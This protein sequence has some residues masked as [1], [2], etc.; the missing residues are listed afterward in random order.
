MS[1][2]NIDNISNEEL[3]FKPKKRFLFFSPFLILLLGFVII[4][5]LKNHFQ[6]TVLSTLVAIIYFGLLFYLFK[7]NQKDKQLIE[8]I[9]YQNLDIKRYLSYLDYVL[10]RQ[11]NKEKNV[12]LNNRIIVDF[13]KGNFEAACLAFGNESI[14]SK[15]KNSPENS[16]LVQ[17]YYHIL[18]AIHSFKDD[19]YIN[20]LFLEFENISLK[21]NKNK[22]LKEVLLQNCSEIRQLIILNKNLSEISKM[23]SSKKLI[24]LM[25]DYYEGRNQLIKE[26][27]F[28]AKENFQKIANEN[29]ELFYVREAKK[30]LEEL[31]NE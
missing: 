8:D 23:K 26:N 15:N 22:K 28:A 3:Y 6:L 29:P 5:I 24:Q 2:P 13:Y 10:Q 17:K 1:L 7:E 19:N 14:S 12:Y 16:L 31:D 4:S 11:K 18:S 27:K 9:L 30:Y 21:N 20:Q 25:F